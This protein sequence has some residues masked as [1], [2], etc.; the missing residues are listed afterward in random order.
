MKPRRTAG[1]VG[2]AHS[3][4]DL[5][6]LHAA[7]Q[8][9]REAAER[10]AAE[11]RAREAAAE[12][13]RHLFRHEVGPVAPLRVPAAERPARPLPEPI[14]RQRALDEAE[15]LREA[16]SDGLDAETLLD[17]DEALGWRRTG[18]GPEVVRR[19]R[20]GE[21]ALQ[22]HCDLHGLRRDEARECLAGFLR[23]SLHTGLRCVRV[24]HGKGNGSPGRT[25]VLKGKVRHWLMQKDEVL[26]FAQA[27]AID[28]GAGALL[29]LLQPSRA[30]TGTA[31][32]AGTSEPR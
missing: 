2:V 9:A 14:A 18:V 6:A 27:R 20:R 32:P 16:W 12:R 28:G 21:W 13:E 7:Q 17:T 15:A 8:R 24:V 26:A 22:A 25:P 5:K 4:A 29:V 1:L 23:D 10:L 31:S 30:R 19:L 3:L 11:A